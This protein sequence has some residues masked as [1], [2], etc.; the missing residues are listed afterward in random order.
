MCYECGGDWGWGWKGA[1]SISLSRSGSSFFYTRKDIA[2]GTDRL[3]K[4]AELQRRMTQGG[5]TIEN[6]HKF[7]KETKSKKAKSQSYK[8]RKRWINALQI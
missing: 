7:P 8:R 5:P 2:R 4:A 3:S 6:L 1:C